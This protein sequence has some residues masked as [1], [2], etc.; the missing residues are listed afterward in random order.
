MKRCNLKAIQARNLPRLNWRDIMTFSD[1]LKDASDKVLSD[2]DE[3]ALTEYFQHFVFLEGSKCPGCDM[4]LV[5]GLLDGLIGRATFTW[6]LAHGEGFCNNCR[7]PARAYHRDVGPIKFL[8]AVLPY[9]PDELSLA[10]EQE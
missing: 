9:H 4:P 6:G 10:K 7:Y 1:T 5:G 8:Q 3:K 2:E